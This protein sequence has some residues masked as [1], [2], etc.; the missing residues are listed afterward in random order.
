MHALRSRSV[1][2]EP[3]SIAFDELPGTGAC[4]CGASYFFDRGEGRVPGHFHCER[5]GRRY[6]LGLNWTPGAQRDGASPDTMP[7]QNPSTKR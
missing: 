6:R 4:R 2:N 7:S 5:C 3:I 1:P